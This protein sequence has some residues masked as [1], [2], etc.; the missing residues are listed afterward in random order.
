MSESRPIKRYSLLL[1][2]NSEMRIK[3]MDNE[4]EIKKLQKLI[5]FKRG[6]HEQVKKSAGFQI[7]TSAPEY[8]RQS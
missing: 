7:R 1:H 6:S 5:D 4:R 8:L 2:E 3:I